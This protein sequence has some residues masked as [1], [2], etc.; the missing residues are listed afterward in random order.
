M[1][2]VSLKIIFSL[3]I[4]G[5]LT[6]SV[7]YSKAEV[8]P[9]TEER[10]PF[11]YLFYLY[12]DN[13]QLFPDRDF[14]FKYDL[15]AKPFQQEVLNTQTP[16][17]G[18]V[19]DVLGRAKTTFEFDPQNGDPSLTTGKISVEAPKFADASE[20]RF[21]NDK[22]ELLLTVDVS[23]SSFCDD[24]G[25]CEEEVGEN[26][27]NC[28][29]DCKV[30]TPSVPTSFPWVWVSVGAGIIVVFAAWFIMRRRRVATQAVPPP[31]TIQ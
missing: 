5:A 23:G 19:I 7:L 16:Y 1:K 21:Y 26:A 9:E 17:R 31:P 25:V 12:Y 6:S 18:E 28:P 14:E 8:I 13:G 10:F 15:L 11:V 3:L 30:I 27:V 4:A 24:N 22:G 2:T 20:V 29:Y